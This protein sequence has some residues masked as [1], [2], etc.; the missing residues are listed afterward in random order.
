MAAD[1]RI[2][3]HSLQARACIVYASRINTTQTAGLDDY[4]ANMLKLI[5]INQLLA[6]VCSWETHLS[7][8]LQHTPCCTSKTVLIKIN[9]TM[10]LAR[11][12]CLRMFGLEET[13]NLFVI[14]IEM[15]YLCML[16]LDHRSY[17]MGNCTQLQEDY[18]CKLRQIR[19]SCLHTSRL[20]H[21]LDEL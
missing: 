18:F 2:T 13:V 11:K 21:E 15:T 4:C 16:Q 6:Y 5:I 10:S 14:D 1:W 17:Q 8:H 9:N 3:N 7:L 12:L 19:K 20:L